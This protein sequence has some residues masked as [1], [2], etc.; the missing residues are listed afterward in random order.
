MLKWCAVLVTV[1]LSGCGVLSARLEY[2]HI[3][4]PTT[5]E[6]DTLDQANFLVRTQREGWYLEGGVGY[7]LNRADGGGFYGP[8]LTGTFRFGREF[9][10][11]R[12]RDAMP[13]PPQCC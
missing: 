8:T 4:H 2:E 11:H 5:R 1:L 3:S 9:V 10:W 13:F 6:E 7:N 12:Y